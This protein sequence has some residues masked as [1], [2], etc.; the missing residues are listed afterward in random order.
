[1]LELPSPEWIRRQQNTLTTKLIIQLHF[2]YCSLI[3]KAINNET[4]KIDTA[5]INSKLE[6]KKDAGA[7]QDKQSARD[8]TKQLFSNVTAVS[9][10]LPTSGSPTSDAS[11]STAN[12]MIKA[13]GSIAKNIVISAVV[14]KG[15]ELF[16][17][18]LDSL[19]TSADQAKENLQNSLGDFN[20][21][22]DNLQEY[23]THLESCKNKIKELQQL[24]KNGT[25]SVVETEELRSLTKLNDELERKISLEKEKQLDEAKKNTG[26]CQNSSKQRST[27]RLYLY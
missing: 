14:F 6:T 5:D 10:L 13:V 12:N 4:N 26:R 19:Y 17:T 15:I 1:M 9:K 25:V 22:T 21:T 3:L 7:G 16:I 2:Y 24:S 23:E 27:K 20:E 18:A 11:L 8:K